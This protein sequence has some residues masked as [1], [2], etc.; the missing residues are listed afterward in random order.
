MDK[1]TSMDSGWGISQKLNSPNKERMANLEL[2][3]IVSMLLVVVLH[4]IGK[5]NNHPVLADAE[6]KAWEYGAWVLESLAIVAVNV[7]MLL[8]GYLLAGSTFKVKRLVQLWL[9]LLFYSAGVG[10]VAAMFGYVKG[11]S[12]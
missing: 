10:I 1:Q 7:Y 4:F 2:L 3:R 11:N 8:S 12:T 5:S 9:Q 6:M